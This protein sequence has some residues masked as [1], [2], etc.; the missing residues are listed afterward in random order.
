MKGILKMLTKKCRR[1][2]ETKSREDFYNAPAARDG[3]QVTCK[4]CDKKANAIWQR[5][6]SDKC[7]A[8]S[9]K[10]RNKVKYRGIEISSEERQVLFLKQEGRCAICQKHETE[11]ARKLAVDHDHKTNK[12]RGLLCLLCNRGLGLFKDDTVR[13]QSAIAYLNKPQ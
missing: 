4:M 9:L 13:F 8:K 12:I 3:K 7:K 11:F 5:M 1:C 2:G 10:W 6:N